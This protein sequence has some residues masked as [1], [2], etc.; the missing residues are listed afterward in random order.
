MAFLGLFKKKDS[1]SRIAEITTAPTSAPKEVEARTSDRDQVYRDSR[2]YFLSGGSEPCIINDISPTGVRVSCQMARSFPEQL[3]ISY[4]GNKRLCP[5]LLTPGSGKRLADSGDGTM[6]QPLSKQ[7][8]IP[9][10][11]EIFERRGTEE[12]LGGFLLVL[13]GYAILKQYRFQSQFPNFYNYH[14]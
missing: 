3:R 2:V 8:I 11:T 12:Y 13:T 9:F 4:G 1:H 10:L 5:E 7:T 6:V 14:R